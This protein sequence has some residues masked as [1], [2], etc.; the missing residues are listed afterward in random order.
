MATYVEIN[1]VDEKNNEEIDVEGLVKKILGIV[2][3]M[4]KELLQ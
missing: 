2:S 3:G 1:V 4:L